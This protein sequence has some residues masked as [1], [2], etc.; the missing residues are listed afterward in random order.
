MGRHAQWRAFACFPRCETGGGV[1]FSVQSKDLNTSRITK[2]WHN[3]LLTQDMTLANIAVSSDTV[4]VV[5]VIENIFSQVI[6]QAFSGGEFF[7]F[8]YV[9]SRTFA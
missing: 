9:I 1:I 7:N 6:R 2:I 8:S 3:S 5:Y 4:E